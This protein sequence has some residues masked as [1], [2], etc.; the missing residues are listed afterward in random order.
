MERITIEVLGLPTRVP[1]RVYNVLKKHFGFIDAL[2]FE[3]KKD[4]GR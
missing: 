3:G 2:I 4:L 1:T